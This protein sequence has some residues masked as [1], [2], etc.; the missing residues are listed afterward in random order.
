M[1]AARLFARVKNLELISSKLVES[2]LT[3][4]YRSVFKGPGIEFSEVREYV[5]GDDP[6][7]IDWNVT[8]RMN[9]V[10]TKTFR[11]EREIVLFLPG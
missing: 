2:L 10:F 1:N 8:S 6:R 7:L 3:G 5:E 4:N 11:E 9:S